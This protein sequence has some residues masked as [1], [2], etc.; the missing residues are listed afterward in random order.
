MQAGADDPS[1]L[2]RALTLLL[3]GGLARGAVEGDPDAPRTARR[4]A[5]ALVRASTSSS[6]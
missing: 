3:D 5:E 1:G 4:S 2:V 6:R